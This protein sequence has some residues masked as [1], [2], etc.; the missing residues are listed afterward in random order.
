MSQHRSPRAVVFDLDGLMFNSEDLYDIVGETILQRRGASYSSE[1]K[2]KMMGLPGPVS[3][4]I[5]I[6][7]HGLDATVEELQ[8]ESDALFEELLP[9]RLEPMP[10]LVE[11]LDAL[12]S[13]SIPKAIATSS[14]RACTRTM[15]SQFGYEPR[16]RF[17]LTSEDVVNGKPDPEVYLTAANRLGV[18]PAEVMVLEDSENGCRAAVAAGAYA[19]AI[20]GIHSRQDDF[21]GVRYVADSLADARIYQSLEIDGRPTAGVGRAGV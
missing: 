18:P 5:M 1:L 13:A 3:L 16:F 9:T 20:P 4:Q 11:L 17:L 2:R 14:G 21:A 12:E 8:A 19:V 10:G 6:D 15:L 7:F